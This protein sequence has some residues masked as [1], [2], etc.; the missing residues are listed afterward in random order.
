[1][2]LLDWEVLVAECPGQCFADDGIHLRPEG[3]KYYA[4]LIGDVIGI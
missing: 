4:D 2:I 1:M 3:Q